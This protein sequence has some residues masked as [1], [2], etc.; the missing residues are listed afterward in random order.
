MTTKHNAL[1]VALAAKDYGSLE[2]A[3]KTDK[4]SA[5]FAVAVD[6]VNS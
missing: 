4:L 5:Q 3:V 1:I 2:H 6:T